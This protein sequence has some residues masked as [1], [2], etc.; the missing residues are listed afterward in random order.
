MDILFIGGTSFVGRHM[1]EAA[2]ISGH[3]VTLFHRGQTATPASFPDAEHV[4]GDRDAD[5]HL[6]IGRA[7]DAVIDVIGYVPRHVRE[8]VGALGHAVGLYCYVSSVS[9]YRTAGVERLCEGSPL[10]DASDLADPDT[11]IVDDKSYGPLEALCEHE[12]L[13]GLPGRVL[14]VRPTYVIGPHDVTDRFTYWVR[15]AAAGGSML[16]AGPA[17]A[18]IQLIDARDLA[19]FTIRLIENGSVGPFNVVG[20][21]APITWAEMLVTCIGVA[22]S[23][24]TPVWVDPGFLRDYG[25][26]V[27]SE[28]PFWRPSDERALF[29]CDPV[30]SA[31]AGLR[32]RTL[33]DSVRDVR[34]WDI[35]RG[36][37]ALAHAVSVKREAEL[38]AAWRA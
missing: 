5:L 7:W 17:S 16:V 33:E 8:T 31:A 12:A 26:S 35:A 32:Y 1:A 4:L 24:A 9:A 28:I 34:A 27:T 2:I 15:R 23:D 36:E 14:I 29:R 25:V 18:P 22:G 37:P 30:K 21:A 3:R 10:F 13:K 38:L 20:P 19:S 11:E 6:L